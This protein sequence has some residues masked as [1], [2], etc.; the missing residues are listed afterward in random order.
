MNGEKYLS[1]AVHAE[2]IKTG[3]L[4]LV[5]APTGAG[6]TTWALNTL[7]E[8]VTDKHRMVYLIDTVNGKEQLRQHEILHTMIE[9]GRRL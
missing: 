9:T 5:E 7:A 2:E 3:Q 6:K 4:N 8:E 1:E